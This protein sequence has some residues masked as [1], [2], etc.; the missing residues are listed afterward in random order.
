MEIAYDDI[1]LSGAASFSVHVSRQG[2]VKNALAALYMNNKLYGSAYTDEAGTAV[3]PI[4]GS[5]PGSG[6]MEVN[7]T[8]YNKMPYFGT[9][10]IKASRKGKRVKHR[11]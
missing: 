9:V 8:A 1:L 7:V 4:N 3:V 11:Q 2:P 5:L 6:T 10:K